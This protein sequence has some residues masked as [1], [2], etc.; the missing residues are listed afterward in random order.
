MSR[1]KTAI[2][3]AI[4]E[5]AENEPCGKTKIIRLAN[6]DWDMAEKYLQSLV[7]DDLI[8][9]EEIEQGKRKNNYRLTKKGKNLKEEIKKIRNISKILQ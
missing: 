8:Q 9:K 2:I 5:T 3:Q 4:L 6:L 7:K 1:S